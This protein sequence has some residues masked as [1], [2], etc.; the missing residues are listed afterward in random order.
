MFYCYFC[1]NII[2]WHKFAL[3]Q[4]DFVTSAV[5]DLLATGYILKVDKR[6]F[7]CSPLSVVEGCSY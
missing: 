7:I 2:I 6:P 5:L 4:K 3:E 1:P